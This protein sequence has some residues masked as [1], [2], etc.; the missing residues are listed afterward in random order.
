MT[1]PFEGTPV[2]GESTPSVNGFE[3]CQTLELTTLRQH[4]FDPTPACARGT[5]VGLA[6]ERSA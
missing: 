5:Y 2:V 6:G 1:E 3:H 4:V